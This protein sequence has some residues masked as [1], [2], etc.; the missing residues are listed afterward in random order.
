MENQARK[1]Q[2]LE[3]WQAVDPARNNT[4]RV[5]KNASGNQNRSDAQRKEDATI[6]DY[7]R[8]GTKRPRTENEK[9]QVS[10]K[11]ESAETKRPRKEI[12]PIR[13]PRTAGMSNTKRHRTEIEP[14]RV[15]RAAGDRKSV[16]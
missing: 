7:Y 8:A 2:E 11:A 14:I 10:R 5:R 3:L 1:R 9:I 4:M 6:S 15:P 12:E 13:V 16:V